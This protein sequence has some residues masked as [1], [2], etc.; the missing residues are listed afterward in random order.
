[1][2]NTNNKVYI[3]NMALSMLKQ[4]HITDLESQDFKSQTL[5]FA[6]D[7]SR[8][9]AL[10]DACPL[11]ALKEAELKLDKIE[12]KF[13]LPSDFLELVQVDGKAVDKDKIKIFENK[14]LKIVAPEP[15][16]LIDQHFINEM[17]YWDPPEHGHTH[18]L[19][20]FPSEKDEHVPTVKIEYIK[21][22][23]D[24]NKFDVKFI[25]YLACL[26]AIN[27]CM[28]FTTNYEI[29]KV[30]E[31]KKQKAYSNVRNFYARQNPPKITYKSTYT[32]PNYLTSVGI[33]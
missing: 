23:Q 3:A 31:E 10:I 7:R 32:R 18:D 24:E 13:V 14:F 29:L 27:V 26:L 9:E 2:V 16:R 15:M 4:T 12:Q 17:G 28:D 8:D 33:K 11:F 30:L 25:S 19:R 22:E 21:R 20:P 1:M 6:Y 5:L